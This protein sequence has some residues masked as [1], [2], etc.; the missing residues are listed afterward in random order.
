MNREWTRIDAKKDKTTADKR[1]PLRSQ[2]ERSRYPNE[3]RSTR[4]YRFRAGDSRT[5]NAVAKT[6]RPYGSPPPPSLRRG[7]PSP[8]YGVVKL[9]SEFLADFHV[10]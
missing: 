1:V 5:L 4:V 8:P 3:T 6:C 2:F 9:R 7:R 10:L